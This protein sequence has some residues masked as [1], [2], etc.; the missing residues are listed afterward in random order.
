MTWPVGRGSLQIAWGLA[1]ENMHKIIGVSVVLFRLSDRHHTCQGISD[2]VGVGSPFAL[3]SLTQALSKFL[4][5]PLTGVF[6]DID[7]RSKDAFSVGS[8]L[9]RTCRS[10][11]N[12]K[13]FE[14]RHYLVTWSLHRSTEARVDA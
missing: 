8:C 3:H 12:C 7:I 13:T 1:V 14:R 4:E 2:K 11:V 5:F 6:A 10:R 9:R